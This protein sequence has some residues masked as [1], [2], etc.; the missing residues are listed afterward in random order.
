MVK[1][2]EQHET[3]SY[4]TDYLPTN[5]NNDGQVFQVKYCNGKTGKEILKKYELE[6][7]KG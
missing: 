3:K 6:D 2:L 5:D 4:N 1:I 7:S